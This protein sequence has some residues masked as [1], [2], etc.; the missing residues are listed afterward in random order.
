VR[1]LLDTHTFLWFLG[2]DAALSPYARQLI[3]DRTNERLLSITK[4][5]T[6][7]LELAWSRLPPASAR[8]SLR[9]SAAAQSQ[10]SALS[11]TCA[12]QLSMESPARKLPDDPLVF[13]Q[14]CVRQQSIFWTYHVNMRLQH[15]SLARPAILDAVERTL[16]RAG[17]SP[18]V[19]R[20]PFLYGRAGHQLSSHRVDTA[21]SYG[22]P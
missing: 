14:P 22:P 21:W 6:V 17:S 8:T 15:R 2:G 20:A 10:R 19:T 11:P 9:L 18:T 12:K 4:S 3:E 7:Y 13:I 1:L 16:A 5:R